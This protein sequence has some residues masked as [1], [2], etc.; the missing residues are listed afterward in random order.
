[1]PKPKLVYEIPKAGGKLLPYGA[2]MMARM[3]FGTLESRRGHNDTDESFVEDD[4][5]SR[6]GE[7][8]ADGLQHDQAPQAKRSNEATR[9]VLNPRKFCTIP[10][11]KH[12]VQ[13]I[14]GL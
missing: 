8:N 13:E 6:R 5:E 2:H 10:I 9:K 3:R 1:M 4:D 11:D 7:G 14:K 12:Q